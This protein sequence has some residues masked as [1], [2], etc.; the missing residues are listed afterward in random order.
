MKVHLPQKQEQ[1]GLH[2]LVQASAGVYSGSEPEGEFGF[3]SLETLGIRTIVSVDGARPDIELAHKHGIR[4]VHIPIGYDGI[5]PTA[6]SA[7]TRAARESDGL[8]YIHCH[9]GKHRGPAAT[10]VACLA[11]G[12]ATKDKAVEILELAGTS[13]DYAGLW[14]DVEHYTPPDPKSSLPELVEVADVPSFAQSMAHVDRCYDRVKQLAD[15]GWSAP[16][17]SAD[18]APAHQAILLQEALF[19]SARLLDEKTPEECRDWLNAAD[20]TATELFEAVKAQD[21]ARATESFRRLERSCKQCH[22]KYR[23]N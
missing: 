22:V 21:G 13:R 18:E 2:N 8:L 19:E 23:D 14:R 12:D 20:A 3:A 9:H 1:P 17:N 7:I 16:A 10:A 6:A 15:A 5:P 4:Y 11:R